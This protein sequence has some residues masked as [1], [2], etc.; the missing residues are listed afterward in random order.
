MH[1]WSVNCKDTISEFKLPFR[2]YLDVF[3][4]F[5]DTFRDF[6]DERALEVKHI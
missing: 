4:D 5:P 2:D 6:L 1:I 3:R